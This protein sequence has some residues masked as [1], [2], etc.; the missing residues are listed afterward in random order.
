MV[1]ELD[2]GSSFP[3][4]KVS[5][6]SKTESWRKECVNGV[7]GMVFSDMNTIRQTRESKR[8]NSNLLAGIL[9]KKEMARIINPFDIEGVNLTEYNIQNKQIILPRI[10]ALTG[11]EYKRRFYWKVKVENEDAISKREEEEK[12]LI[13]QF[14]QTKIL[15]EA[16]QEGLKD[17]E[18]Q[19][20]YQKLN[21]YLNY[22]WQ[23]MREM[24]ATRILNYYTKYLKTIEVFNKGFQDAMCY[25]EEIYAVDEF[26]NEPKI[27]KCDPRTTWFLLTSQS[28]QIDD[29]DTIVEEYY[30]PIGTVIDQYY[31]ELT[32]AQIDDLESKRQSVTLNYSF[33]NAQLT[34]TFSS[35][36]DGM[37]AHELSRLD[38]NGIF[39]YRGGIRIVHCRWKSLKKVG[40]LSFFDEQGNEQKKVVDESFPLSKEEKDLGWS[41]KWFW[42]NEAWE[43]TKIGNNIYVK[44]QPRNIQFRKKDDISYCNLGYYGSVYNNTNNKVQSLVDVMKPY[45]YNYITIWHRIMEALRKSFGKIGFIDLAWIPEGWDVDMWMHYATNMGWAVKDSFAESKK[46]AAKGKLAGN[47][48]SQQQSI[49]LEQTQ[50]INNH[51]E[52]LKQIDNELDYI[53]GIS[54]Q[55]I[56]VT[57]PDTGLGVYQMAQQA[58]NNITE[59]LFKRHDAIKLRV[60]EGILETAKFC[61]RNGSKKITDILDDMSVATFTIDGEL[62]NEA[63]YGIVMSDAQQEGETLQAL[64]SA[65][66]AA[67]QTGV[68]DI[69]QMLD[70][71]SEDSMS[72]KRRKLEKSQQDKYQRE[73]EQQKA[74]QDHEK[75]I[76]DRQFQILQS[77]QELK[78]YIAELEAQT[79][80]TVAEIGNYFQAAN[81]DSDANGI[82]DPIE[83]GK[84]ELDKISQVQDS[85]HKHLDRQND[86]KI[87]KDKLEQKSR[88]T[89]AQK[90]IENKKIELEKIKEKNRLKIENL[91]AETAIRV[92]KKKAATVKKS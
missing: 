69:I 64:K 81:T 74:Q 13:M 19:K 35:E 60:L 78:K 16:K 32:P 63:E 59:P 29:C 42:I 6:K 76:A 80:I 45:Q 20:E 8:I 33:P 1:S 7:L 83:I 82:P 24:S 66:D 90:T 4:Q 73:Q 71:Y 3:P 43:G 87:E 37:N 67:L 31:D 86:L 2:L 10:Q 11:E 30:L 65:S 55:R 27:R 61:L 15:T 57:E 70:I 41:I 44:M 48:T 88:E 28:H 75:E 53:T 85:I 52:L 62:L 40:T 72:A 68:I 92:A 17:D 18:L 21:H 9:D 91:K 12:K 36:G 84:L 56:G 46:G 34:S 89:K 50:F 26:N 54:K 14:L 38:G 51:L 22:E 39:D 77:E 23:D 25:G 49:D 47:L 79:K 58:T 5:F